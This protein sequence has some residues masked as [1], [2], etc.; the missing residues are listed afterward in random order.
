MAESPENRRSQSDSS[1]EVSVRIEHEIG[2]G[3]GSDSKE[4]ESKEVSNGGSLNTGRS[5]SPGL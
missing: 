4:V 3:S 1:G 2:G 5:S